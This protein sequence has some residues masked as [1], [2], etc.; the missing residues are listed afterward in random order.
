MNTK[1]LIKARLLLS[2]AIKRM[3]VNVI[4][5]GKFET[6]YIKKHDFESARS[7]PLFIGAIQFGR[8]INAIRSC[9]RTIIRIIDWG[10]LIDTKDRLEQLLILSS[11]T[12]EGIKEFFRR[13]ADFSKLAIWQENESAIAHLR[14]EYENRGSRYWQVIHDIRNY[15]SFHFLKRSIEPNINSLPLK[16]EINFAIGKSMLE[17]DIIFCLGDDIILD[18]ILNRDF[19]SGTAGERMDQLFDFVMNISQELIHVMYRVIIEV[20]K[21]IADAKRKRL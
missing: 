3:R 6:V 1:Y 11:Y 18:Y 15:V 7:D 5:V 17:K 21:P 10:R 8:I 13:E 20:L 12:Y 19:L 2:N 4:G 16:D 9:Q 14:Q